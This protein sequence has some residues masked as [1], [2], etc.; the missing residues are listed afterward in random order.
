M[1]NKIQI[2][3][4]VIIGIVI[5]DLLTIHWDVKGDWF[6]SLIIAIAFMLVFIKTYKIRLVMSIILLILYLIFYCFYF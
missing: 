5:L 4:V 3:H 1:K 6:S 2:L